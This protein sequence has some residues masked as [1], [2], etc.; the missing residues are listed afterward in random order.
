M[1]CLSYTATQTY[2]TNYWWFNPQV[3][4]SFEDKY[5][6]LAARNNRLPHDPMNAFALESSFFAFSTLFGEEFF[7][8]EEAIKFCTKAYSELQSHTD[9]QKIYNLLRSKEARLPS[10]PSVIY[11]DKWQSWRAFFNVQQ[12]TIVSK[13]YSLSELRIL[14]I[15]KYKA[16]DKKPVNLQNFFKSFKHGD[17]KIPKNP[18]SFYRKPGE[19]VSWQDLFG[20][21]DNKWASYQAIQEFCLRMYQKEVHKPKNLAVYYLALRKTYEEEISLPRHPESFYAKKNEW[22][23]FKS[24]FGML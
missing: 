19:W 7:T 20:L 21:E 12:F 15:D 14:C 9:L 1:D 10:A 4:E 23:S 13:Y 17:E 8:F 16:Q 18:F 11:K 22:K 5:Y 2:L 3:I 24:L 6:E